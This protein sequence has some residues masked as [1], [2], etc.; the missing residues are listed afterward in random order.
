LYRSSGYY[1]SGMVTPPDL[2]GML[3]IDEFQLVAAF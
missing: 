2:S 1:L 3:K